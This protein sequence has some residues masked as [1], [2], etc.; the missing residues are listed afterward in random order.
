MEK[1][2][3]NGAMLISAVFGTL[4]TWIPER[5]SEARLFK[6]LSSTSFGVNNFGN[7]YARR[8]LF[9]FHNVVNL[10]KISETQ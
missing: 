10:M 1:H 8:L 6:S 5:C 2:V 3:N 7:T 9:F 4:N